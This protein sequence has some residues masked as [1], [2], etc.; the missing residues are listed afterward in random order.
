MTVD[1]E[2]PNDA[3]YLEAFIK[4]LVGVMLYEINRMCICALLNSV[5]YRIIFKLGVVNRIHFMTLHHPNL[6]PQM[7]QNM[8]E[9]VHPHNP[10]P[11][12]NQNMIYPVNMIVC[13]PAANTQF[14]H[15]QR[16]LAK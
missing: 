5:I 12:M 13:H 9:I 2:I 14:L 1:D 6:V 3:D 15:P 11:Q 16:R 4:E 10:A 7:H 8:Q